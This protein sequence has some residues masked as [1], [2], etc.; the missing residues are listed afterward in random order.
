MENHL[1]HYVCLDN[2]RGMMISP[3]DIHVS[4]QPVHNLLLDTFNQVSSTIHCILHHKISELIDDADDDDDDDDEDIEVFY[5]YTI[6]D[7][8]K[9]DKWR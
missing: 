7:N 4:K 5:N 8:N 9:T 2:G 1:L 3:C 6:T